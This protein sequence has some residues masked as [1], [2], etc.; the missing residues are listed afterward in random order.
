MI[1]GLHIEMS[2]EKLLGLLQTKANYHCSKARTYRKQ[3]DNLTEHG[4]QFVIECAETFL[5]LE[6]T[7][8]RNQS[9]RTLLYD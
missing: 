8:D 1:Q 2:S 3:A 4:K 7:E 9:D 6:Q 5:L